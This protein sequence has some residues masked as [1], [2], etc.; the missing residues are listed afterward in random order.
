V[1]RVVGAFE[2]YLVQSDVV[3]LVVCC[4]RQWRE[5]AATSEAGGGVGTEV[6]Y[7]VGSPGALVAAAG[8]EDG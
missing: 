4:T 8:I 6:Q 1:E 7:A 3:G 2:F 5:V